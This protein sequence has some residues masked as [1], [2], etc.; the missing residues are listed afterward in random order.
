MRNRSIIVPDKDTTLNVE[1]WNNGANNRPQYFR[2]WAATP[3]S[4]IN[5]Y[6]RVSMAGQIASGTPNFN[7]D[8]DT[9]AVRGGGTAGS[10]L[11]W[12]RS[13]YLTAN[14]RPATAMAT[15][16]APTNYWSARLRF[17]KSTVTEGQSISYKYL[18]GYDWEGKD[19][20]QSQ[21]NRTFTIPVGMK[22]TTLKCVY[23]NNEKPGTRAN[24]DTVKITFIADLAR[25]RRAA[26]S[27]F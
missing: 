5:V 15:Q 17:P 13:T 24:P 4:F 14:R 1:F 2:P 6:F 9:V 12:G 18:I 22:D 10:D 19:E 26:G 27:T 11:D 20:L 7:S 8:K 25:P 16:R 3:D 23:Y 21:P